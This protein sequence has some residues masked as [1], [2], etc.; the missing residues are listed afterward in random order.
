LIEPKRNG[1]AP[2]RRIL[3]RILVLV[4]CGGAL[5]W[6]VLWLGP[7]RIATAVKEADPFWLALSALFVAVRYLVWAFK[8]HA[9]LWR[10]GRVGFGSSLANVLAGVFV[11]LTTPTAKLGGG[12][13]RAALLSRRTG[14][15]FATSYG[16]ALADQFTNVLGNIMLGGV[17]M[18][19]AA[20]KL[21][22]GSVRTVLV[23]LG[24]AALAG[25]A[26]MVALRGWAWRR[27]QAAGHASRVARLAPKR[28]RAKADA[29]EGAWLHRLLEPLLHT[30]ASRRVVPQDLGLAAFSCSFLALS[31][32][33]ALRAVGLDLSLVEAGAAVVLAG[34]AGTLAGTAGGIGATELA[35]IGVM[36]K[37]NLPPEAAAAGALLHRA[38][39]YFVS[40]IWGAFGLVAEGRYGKAAVA[41][42]AAGDPQPAA[43]SAES[44]RS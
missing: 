30:G 35:L 1:R 23:V 41:S 40:L 43:A 8:W 27:V 18:L 28:W 32:A 12:F 14:W 2:L 17:F 13:V 36:G 11:N 4:A 33:C 34:F 21:P 44:G 42:L 15:G 39:Y 16:W 5:V 20:A 38:A 19:A 26:A 7:A 3:L 29:A 37:L 9:M 24:G 25:P 22:A 10:R 31:H 6:T